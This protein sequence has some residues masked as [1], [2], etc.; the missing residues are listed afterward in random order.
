MPLRLPHP[1]LPSLKAP[2][3]LLAAVLLFSFSGMATAAQAGPADQQQSAS[4][5][6]SK[7]QNAERA[8][9]PLSSGVMAYGIELAELERAY[10]AT[11]YHVL[12]YFF[13]PGT[14]LP[15]VRIEA[16]PRLSET[17][18]APA[19][20]S[21]P[22]VSSLPGMPNYNGEITLPRL[23]VLNMPPAF[24]GLELRRLHITIYADTLYTTAMQEFMKQLI[25]AAVK[26]E[27]QRGDRVHIVP[28]AFPHETYEQLMAAVKADTTTPDAEPPSKE[29]IKDKRLRKLFEMPGL[30]L[31]ISSVLLIFAIVYLAVSLQR[32]YA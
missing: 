25:V 20:E 15:D 2:L 3:L 5:A 24:T 4:A 21:A 11:L 9:R 8:V 7:I 13:K 22:S 12:S 19:A 30:M 16:R 10:D 28:L 17:Q 6:D 26:V 18:T 31:A 32:R 14:F 27:P 23:M 1:L 29:S